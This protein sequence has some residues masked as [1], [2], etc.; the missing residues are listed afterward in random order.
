MKAA[1]EIGIVRPCFGLLRRALLP[2][3]AFDQ[4][5]TYAVLAVP[6]L[7]LATVDP[8]LALYA[9][10]GGYIG[11]NVMQH[12]STPSRL[13]LAANQ[14]HRVVRFLDGA[15]LL[16]RT[17]ND[18]EWISTH[19]RLKRWATDVIRL[20]HTANGLLVTGRLMDLQIIARNLAT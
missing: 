15:R 2:I 20:K 11:A 14:E 4:L 12:R 17:G 10:V 1:D 9:G 5:V 16:K 19:G 18:D 13:L 8:R 3:Y 6:L 7:W